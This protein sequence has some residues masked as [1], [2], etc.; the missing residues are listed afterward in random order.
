MKQEF[1]IVKLHTNVHFCKTRFPE[2]NQ[3]RLVPLPPAI[4]LFQV[5]GAEEANSADPKAVH[6]ECILNMGPI[7]L[8]G[9]FGSE[10]WVMLH[11]IV[12]C[13]LAHNSVDQYAK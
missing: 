12:G 1:S 6:T 9:S 3:P 2:D 4:G 7:H 10:W 11:G 5:G 13:G 8:N